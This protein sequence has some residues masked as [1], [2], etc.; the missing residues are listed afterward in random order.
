MRVRKSIE[1]AALPQEVWPFL[2]EPEKVLQWCVT[3]RRFEYTGERRSGVGTPLYIEEEAAG[4]LSKMQFKVTEWR[5]NE[6]LALSMVSG[7]GYRSY[8]QQLSLEPSPSGS[9]FTFE[10]EIVL[11]YGVIGKLIGLVAER[12]SAAT[13]DKMEARLKALAEASGRET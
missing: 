13:V 12:M 3:F 5:E 4:R 2:V 7:A 1:I 10:E 8:E 9:R 6:K 11:P